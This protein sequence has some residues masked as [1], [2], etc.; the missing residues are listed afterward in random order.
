MLK[1]IQNIK[2]I[3]LWGLLT[4]GLWVLVGCQ[5]P[6]KRYEYVQK[7]MGTA[8]RIVFYAPDQS[9]ADA[10]SS[11]AFSR[12]SELNAKLSDYDSQSELNQLCNLSRD[13]AP[14]EPTVVSADLWRVLRASQAM[15]QQSNGA[16]DV[17]IGPCVRLWR[18]TGRQGE[19]PRGQRLRE[20]MQSVGYQKLRLIEGDD[21][22]GPRVQ[23]L[24][25]KMRLDL[26][27]VAKGYA[28]D[29]AIK[30]LRAFGVCSALIDAGGDVAVSDPP[31]DRRAWRLAV[32][33]F[34]LDETED[35]QY[36][37]L[38]NAAIATSG[39]VYRYVEIDGVR[40]SHLIDPRTGLGLRRRIGVSVIAADGMTAD[41]LASAVSVLGAVKGL[42]LIE[43]TPGAEARISSIEGEKTVVYQSPHWRAGLGA[44]K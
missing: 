32:Q 5:A 38:T 11:A 35:K 44:A 37:L 23:L 26:G 3:G 31:P 39:D 21:R 36:V 13:D 12:I 29:E 22:H 27:G 34:G 41:A 28:A 25:P 17:T 30:I 18:R 10:A 7:H 40:Y 20:A 14:T 9:C 16:F 24:T 2:R 6:L 42:T 15:S 19:L 43:K 33:P 8:F 4:V 1:M